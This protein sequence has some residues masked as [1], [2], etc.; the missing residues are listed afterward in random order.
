MPP[1]RLTGNLDQC[2]LFSVLLH[3]MAT[4]AADPTSQGFRDM[5]EANKSWL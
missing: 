2:G 3:H 1:Y 4:D 5:E